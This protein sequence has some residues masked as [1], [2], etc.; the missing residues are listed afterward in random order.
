MENTF[1]YQTW[2]PTAGDFFMRFL[3]FSI[4]YWAIVFAMVAYIIQFVTY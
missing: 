1:L 4:A 2:A 3:Y